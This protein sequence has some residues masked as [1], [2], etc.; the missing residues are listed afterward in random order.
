MTLTVLISCMH[1]KDA[2]IIEKSNIQTD[3]VV[4]NQCDENSVST[5]SF[6]NL[7]GRVCTAKIIKTTERGL[8]N[9]R[10]MAV[11]YSEG[12]DIC[13]LCDDDEYLVDNYEDIILDAY[14]SVG[15]DVA[16]IS[17][18][19][20]REDKTMPTK[21]HRL[22][23]YHICRTSS[24]EITSRRK[25]IVDNGI[26][27]DRQL[28]SGTP[29]GPGEEIKFLMDIRKK[30]Y[31]MVYIPSYIGKLL[32]YDSQWFKGFTKQYFRNN[33]WFSHRV[34][35]LYLGYLFVIYQTLHHFPKYKKELSFWDAFRSANIGFFEK[36]AIVE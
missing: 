10:N 32:S 13:L 6:K 4:I 15:N 25:I 9:S 3:V 34:F 11:K 31:K 20:E 17:F 27:F 35:G 1:Q 28:G 36:R 5:F 12:A 14:E 23:I 8:S 30:G 26:E 24:V 2:T 7:K 16:M 33:G 21:E 18:A 22:N 19:Y 29:N